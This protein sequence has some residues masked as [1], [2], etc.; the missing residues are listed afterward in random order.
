MEFVPFIFTCQKTANKIPTPYFQYEIILFYFVIFPIHRNRS[1][2]SAYIPESN[3]QPEVDEIFDYEAI[4]PTGTIFI[5]VFHIFKLYGGKIVKLSL[6]PFIDIVT[7]YK[8]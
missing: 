3:L 5:E 8:F 7:H 4:Q 6:L 2:K 1:G